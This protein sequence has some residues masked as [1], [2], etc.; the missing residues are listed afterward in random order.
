MH[1]ING[2]RRPVRDGRGPRRHVLNIVPFEIVGASDDRGGRGAQ[3]GPETERIGL[4]RQQCAVGANDFIFIIYAFADAGGEYLPDSAI[5]A[6][7][8]L[9][10]AAIPMIEVADHGHAAR[11]RR[12]YR[13]Q[14][15]FN[16]FM[17]HRMRTE[18]IIETLVRALDQEV[19]I[20][21]TQHRPVGVGVMEYP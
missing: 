12:P 6:L 20:H 5:D 4:E 13:E 9:M 21:R 17:C 14:R 7:P 2:N 10:A 11:I 3:F 1:F 19:V 15:A 8:H 16:A 18:P